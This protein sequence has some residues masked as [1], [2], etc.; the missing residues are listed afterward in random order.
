MKISKIRLFLR[1]VYLKGHQD[2]N[3]KTT[4]MSWEDTIIKDISL[5]LKEGINKIETFTKVSP[6]EEK[7]VIHIDKDQVLLAIDS[8]CETTPIKTNRGTTRKG[9]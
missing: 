5:T 9:E 1:S 2:G 8:I 7:I 4:D 6:K 3:L